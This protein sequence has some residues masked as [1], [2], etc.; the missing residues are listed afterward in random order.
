[1]RK[2]FKN[3]K[4][5]TWDKSKFITC[6]IIISLVMTCFSVV[7][8]EML[9]A[10]VLLILACVNILVLELDRDKKYY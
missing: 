2:L 6:I 4:K 3:I 9:Q 8:N 10:S 1:M 7:C 5:N